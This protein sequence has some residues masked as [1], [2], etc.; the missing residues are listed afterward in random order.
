LTVVLTLEGDARQRGEAYGEQAKD[1]IAEAAERWTSDAGTSYRNL[2]DE[3]VDRSSFRTTATRFSPGLVAEV[4]GIARASGVDPRLVW[5]LNLL[6]EDWWTRGHLA[7]AEACSGL[8]IR[9]GPNQPALIAQNMDLPGWLDGLQVLLDIRPTDG[10]PRV[11]APSYAGMVATNVLNEH[12]VGACVNTL[13]QLPTSNAGL[14]VAFMVRL[15]A[16]Q[17][18]FADAAEVLRTTPHASGQNFIL[19]APTAVADFECGAGTISEYAPH[20]GRLGHTN[21]PIGQDSSGAPSGPGALSN[22][23][24]RF[25]TLQQRLADAPPTL[26][27]ADVAAILRD[28]PLCRGA[29]GDT[30]FTF[31]SV[32]MELTDRPVLHLTSGP[33]NLSPYASW[34]FGDSSE[35]L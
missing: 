33:P 1:L 12:G 35:H 11:L 24:V 28:R 10:E 31:Y 30:G 26:G 9:P 25:D 17:R 27:L 3:L 22:S 29:D 7:A 34:D 15:L 4:D 23:E 21:H 18:S 32:V 19:G 6:D 20:A 8:G 16:A 2:L 5:A 13:S 14:P